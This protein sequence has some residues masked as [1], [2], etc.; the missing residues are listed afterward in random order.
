MYVTIGTDEIDRMASRLGLFARSDITDATKEALTVVAFRARKAERRMLPQE[1]DRPRPF[2]L[3]SVAVRKGERNVATGTLESR[4]FILP[5]MAE[6]LARLEEGGEQEGG[7][8]IRDRALENRYGDLGRRGYERIAKRMRGELF[9]IEFKGKSG[10]LLEGLF[11]RTRARVAGQGQGDDI[12][13]VVGVLRKDVMVQ[14]EP[15]LEFVETAREAGL[16]L[17]SEMTRQITKRT[18]R[19]F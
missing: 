14:K 4:V 8:I 9:R 13:L 19:R 15:Q 12:E 6:T 17:R 11:R 5:R 7:L 1:L 18:R 10:Q 3:A 2:T 16:T